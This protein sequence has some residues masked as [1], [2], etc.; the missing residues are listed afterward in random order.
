MSLS[1]DLSVHAREAEKEQRKKARREKWARREKSFWKAFLFTKDGKP[2]SGLLIYTFCLS[3]VF[4]GLYIAAFFYFIDWLS[5]SLETRSPLVSNLVVSAAV[6]AVGILTGWLIHHFSKEKRLFF[7]TFVW[8]AVYLVLVLITM[9]IMLRGTG[10]VE[11][12]LYF[13]L[14]FMVI[15][16]ISG[17]PVSFLLYR[18]D[19]RPPVEQEEDKPW[20]QYTQRR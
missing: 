7:G 12:F 13:Y 10:A 18:K 5:P 14:W 16:V 9:L 1:D 15:P 8:M 20:K 17:L 6:S 4:I 11:A 3:F 19:Y 2:K